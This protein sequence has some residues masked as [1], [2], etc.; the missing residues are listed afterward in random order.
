MKLQAS[1]TWWLATRLAWRDLVATKSKFLTA[2]LAVSIGVAA[3]SGVRGFSTAF[4]DMLLRDARVLLAA[5]IAASIDHEP[6]PEEQSALEQLV[7]QGARI[8]TVTELMTMMDSKSLPRPFPVTLKAI[9]P[10]YYPFYGEVE[11]TPAKQLSE[12]L[13]EAAVLVSPDLLVRLGLNTGDTVQVG[14]ASFH[15]AGILRIEPDR[16]TGRMNFGPRAMISRQA[17]EQTQLI[18]LGSRA[19]RRILL[20]LP[21]NGLALEDALQ[22]V[23]AALPGSRITDYRE[24]HPRISRG[25]DRA[26]NLL[27]LVSMLALTIG[28]LGVA[29]V[30]YAHLQQRLDTIAIM[31]CYGATS[32]KIIQ[33]FLLQTLALGVFGSLLGSFLGYLLQGIA[34]IFV[35][36]Y[37]PQAPVFEWQPLVT[38][39]VIS[40]GTLIAL[41]FSLPTL[42]SIRNVKPA[43]IFRRAMSNRFETTSRKRR[44]EHFSRFAACSAI[45]AVMGLIAVWL[46][47]STQLGGWFVGGLA[48]N[49][50]VL[51]L[52]AYLL[53]KLLKSIPSI[54]PLRLPLSVRHGIANLHRPGMQSEAILIALGIGV[55]FTLTIYM[56]QTTVLA[57][58]IR[59]LPPDMPNAYLSNI[60]SS[61]S[62]AL[63]EFLMKQPGIEGQILLI[64]TVP[65]RL[66]SID[67]QD[68]RTIQLEGRNRRM[69]RTRD[70]TWAD[71]PPSGFEIMQGEWWD[72]DETD[73]VVS[74]RDGMAR[75]LGLATGSRISWKVGGQE[76]S[77]RIQAI[78]QYEGM[79]DRVYDYVFSRAAL[80]GTSASYTGGI[81]IMS[82]H[83]LDLTRNIFASFPSVLVVNAADFFAL[84][85]EVV[86]QIAF[87]I[88]F[89]SAFAIVAGIIIL[90]ACVAATR[91]Q[92][93]QEV[94]VLKTL[95]ATR[96]RL[97]K[98]FSV[99][100]LILGG[101]AGTVGSLLAISYTGLLTNNI[102]ELDVVIDWVPI[103]VT[104]LSTALL[105]NFAGWG[106]SLH[107]LGSKPLDVLRGE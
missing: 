41:I 8:T 78:H 77:A 76:V 84:V 12:I 97:V 104:I 107:I 86:D 35:V 82:E 71:E 36:Q 3:L 80:E 83:S 53:L 65:A 95:G 62:T 30:I 39:Q 59:D 20:E 45:V 1:K 69:L 17:L 42:L 73:Y 64:P 99:E 23:Q 34:P 40:V 87:V 105:A 47:D 67:G 6:S 15:I 70:I 88:R 66:T 32:G 81:R 74:I 106:A 57:Q 98:I 14:S 18:Q 52:C 29:M 38:L 91:Y 2:I 46:S 102:L 37:F 50:S 68:I 27:S 103:V 25:L 58:F 101:V 60:S 54:L 19:T 10:E 16:M 79:S 72:A 92:R 13:E 7:L 5:D 48:M 94:A 26:T 89:V 44:R 31:K 43:L 96:N 93:L 90:I 56:L 9:D 22:A 33:I 55:T 100:F 75:A 4:R 61:E 21:E 51:A 85:Q 11:T 63:E 28:G 49:V 24:T